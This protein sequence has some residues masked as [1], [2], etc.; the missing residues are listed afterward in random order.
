MS[1]KITV[2][3]DDDLASIVEKDSIVKQLNVSEV[4]RRRLVEAYYASE[5][6]EEKVVKKFEEF[7]KKLLAF[8]EEKFLQSEARDVRNLTYVLSNH[9]LIKAM[10]RDAM[11]SDLTP[12]EQVAKIR[13]YVSD[14]KALALKIHTVDALHAKENIMSNIYPEHLE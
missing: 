12:Q 3:L 11:Y 10:I 9:H 2:I 13:W 8:V 6:Q 5:K 14:A 4:L 1:K 7:E